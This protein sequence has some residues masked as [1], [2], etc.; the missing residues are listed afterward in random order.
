M[1]PSVEGHDFGDGELG[2]AA[3]IGKW[4]IKDGDSAATCFKNIHLISADTEAAN[5][6]QIGRGSKDF[7]ANLSLGTNTQ[8][9]N[10]V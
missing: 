10:A 3:G 7:A 1:K 9:V 4:R 6:N 8:N 5:R 2:Y